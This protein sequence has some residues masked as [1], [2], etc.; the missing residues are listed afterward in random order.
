MLFQGIVFINGFNLG[1]YWPVIGPQITLYVPKEIL[2]RGINNI[3]LIEL[4][5]KP[6]NDSVAFVDTPILNGY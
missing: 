6:S 5:L 1:R 4:Q 2:Q 3:V